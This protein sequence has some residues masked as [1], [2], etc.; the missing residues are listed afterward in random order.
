MSTLNRDPSIHIT[1]YQFR[2]ILK[3][4]EIKGFPLTEFFRLAQRKA[5]NSRS[6]SI[7]NNKV[8]KQI[9]N[10]LLADKGDA[11]LVADIIYSCRIKLHH[12][13]VR[14]ITMANSRD[15][16]NCKKLA[17]ICNNFCQD[18]GFTNIREGFIKYISLGLQR[19]S[20]ARNLV[21]RLIAMS[22]NVSDDYAH[23]LEIEKDKDPR[24]TED[25]H[26]Y[27]VG[28]IA[29]ITGITETYKDQPSKYVYFVRLKDFLG[30]HGW[31]NQY[32][33]YIDAQFE[34]LS[35]CNGIPSLE[36]ICSDKAIER[37]NKYLYKNNKSKPRDPVVKGSLWDK[38]KNA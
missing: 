25:I 30:D 6:I 1:K 15:W 29:S 10:I 32:K 18:F 24:V 13:N 34:A 22:D 4:L 38:I 31:L 35:F 3:Q 26:D 19:L 12:R 14:K 16:T 5:I 9:D 11:S 33:D 21:Q 8:N 2:R 27:Y 23:Q 7:S 17:E 37:Y 36:T 20:D 28:T